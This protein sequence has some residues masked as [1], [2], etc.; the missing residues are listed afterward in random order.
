M[1]GKW[2]CFRDAGGRDELVDHALEHELA[3]LKEG[4]GGG[5]G[6]GGKGQGEER[7]VNGK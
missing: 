1:G 7:W 5:R 2:F 6:E 4:R 3:N